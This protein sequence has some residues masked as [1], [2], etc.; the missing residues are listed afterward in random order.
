MANKTKLLELTKPLQSEDYNVKDFNDNFD[1]IDEYSSNIQSNL[2][3]IVSKINN[4]THTLN[5]TGVNGVLPVSKGGTGSSSVVTARQN[6]GLKT[7]STMGTTNS[8]ENVN[9]KLVTG[10]AVYNALTSKADKQHTHS[11]D[12]ITEND[13]KKIM[14]ADERSK[15]SQLSK[16]CY[17][18]AAS[19]TDESLKKYANL[20]CPG[21]DDEASIHALFGSIPA[22]STIHM[23]AGTYKFSNPLRLFKAVNL[24]GSGALTKLININGGY[25][26]SI[27]SSF[28]TVKDM[29]LLRYSS[30]VTTKSNNSLVEF[31]SLHDETLSDIKIKGCIFDYKNEK[32][33]AQGSI[34]AVNNPNSLN[35]LI[36]LRILENTF[37]LND[38][39]F[40]G[41]VID[42]SNVPSSVSA[43]VGAN[44]STQSISIKIKDKKALWTYG[45]D[46]TP[47]II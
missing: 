42:L 39:T 8:V 33:N 4:H 44:V 23:L 27:V 38:D 12:D 28:V 41:C 43:V 11:I 1:K 40:T 19:D 15:L 2:D 22:G 7:A 34:I 9:T 35:N 30:E 16:Y 46:T 32:E 37:V 10:A 25:I 47:E 36:Q 13:T 45:Q 29:Q 20:K 31:Y 3:N 24:I 6:L 18:I 14:T 21:K 26:I 17:I 5:G